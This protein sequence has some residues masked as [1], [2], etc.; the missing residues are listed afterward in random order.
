MTTPGKVDHSAVEDRG[1]AGAL[2]RDEWEQ[3]ARFLWSLLDNID[4]LD[5]AAR[6]NDASYRAHTRAQQKRRWEVGQ[7]DGHLVR[8]NPPQ[9]SDAKGDA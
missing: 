6:D 3:V 4:T 5:D 2:E 1:P 9:P 7:S 8:F